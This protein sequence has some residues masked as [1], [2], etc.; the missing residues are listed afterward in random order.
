M[1]GSIAATSIASLAEIP[2]IGARQWFSQASIVISVSPV[3]AKL[4]PLIAQE[5]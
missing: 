3:P 5:Y 4:C 1:G 2:T